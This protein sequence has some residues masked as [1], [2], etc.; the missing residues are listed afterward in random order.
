LGLQIA[1]YKQ[2]NELVGYLRTLNLKASLP[3][4]SVID[5]IEIWTNYT[6]YIKQMHI[7]LQ[8]KKELNHYIKDTQYILYRGFSF[9]EKQ[10]QEFQS[11]K[12]Y[13]IHDIITLNSTESS[14]T[15]DLEIAQ[16]HSGS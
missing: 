7:P 11:T 3:N 14:W 2:Y 13:N 15:I 4:Q 8:L 16:L 9:T 10:F 1:L 12:H 5:F 6:N